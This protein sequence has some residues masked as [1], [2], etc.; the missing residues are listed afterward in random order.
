MTTLLYYNHIQDTWSVDTGQGL[1]PFTSSDEIIEYLGVK[2]KEVM[3]SAVG[4]DG[5]CWVWNL[6]A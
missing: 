3:L 5:D 6:T 1:Q 2:D 4:N